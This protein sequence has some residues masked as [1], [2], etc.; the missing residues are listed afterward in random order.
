MRRVPTC[1]P[2]FLA[3]ALLVCACAAPAG[4]PRGRWVDLTHGF[5][6]DTIY[7]PTSGDFELT[8]LSAE[9]TPAGYWYAANRFC[10]AE[11]GGTHVDAPIHFAAGRLTVDRLPLDRL[12]GPACVVDVAAACA[13]NRDDRVTAGD[14]QAWEARHGCL[15]AGAIVLLRTGFGHLWPDRAL[16]LGTAR[17]GAEGVAEL[18]F[19]GLHPDAARWL[20]RERDI[21]AIGIDTASIDF[22][23]STLYESHVILNEADIPVFENVAA[24]DELP[25]RGA[26]VIALPMKIEGG[27][28]GPVRIAALVPD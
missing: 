12:S 11:H 17:R 10:T 5:G 3:L 26:W 4:L 9:R 28:G 2:G 21:A 1:A 18:R 8:V 20:V 24:L 19:P 27:S 22:G 16:Y 13:A 6:P 23:R 15:P 25:E 14:L 7:W